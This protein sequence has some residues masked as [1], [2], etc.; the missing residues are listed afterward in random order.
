M[1]I[2]AG[3]CVGDLKEAIADKKRRV[4][5]CDADELRL[6]AAR[7]PKGGAWMVGDPN[8]SANMKAL[9]AGTTTADLQSLMRDELELDSTW[10][11]SDYFDESTPSRRAV[12]LLVKPP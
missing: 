3:D 10:D 6:Y 8:T 7:Q 4:I 2:G 12:H 5:N 9:K 1:N 11:V